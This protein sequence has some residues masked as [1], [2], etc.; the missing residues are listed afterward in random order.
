M[1]PPEGSQSLLA[2]AAAEPEAVARQLVARINAHDLEGLLAL[3]DP[4]VVLTDA[5]G[6]HVHGRESVGKAWR[7]YFELFPDYRLDVVESLAAGGLV[8][9]FGRA[10]GTLA[11][12]SDPREAWWSIPAAWRVKVAGGLVAELQVY[13]DNKPVYEILATR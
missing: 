8:A 13:A 2:F 4:D 9:L 6:R 12:A 3:C 7:F 5:L 1:S 11:S 10:F